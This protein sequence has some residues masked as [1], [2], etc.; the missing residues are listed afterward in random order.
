[1]IFWLASYPKSGNTWLRFF[2]L[3]LLIGKK[4]DLNLNHLKAII[5]YP[6]KSQFKDLLLDNSNLEEVA[7]NWIT[8]QNK[9]NSDKT[10]RFFKTHNM[11]G[12]F[13]NYPFTDADNTLATIHIVRDPRNVITSLKNHYNLN[14]YSEAKDFLFFDKQIL[15]LSKQEK[16]KYSNKNH[17]LPQII[18]SWKTHYLSWKNMKKNYLLVKYEDLIANPINGFMKISKFISQNLKL[19][20]SDEQI[21]NAIKSSSFNNLKEMENT[22]GFTESSTNE[23]GNKNKFFYLGPKNNW[24][25][26]LDESTV[27]N[28]N[29]EFKL[30]MKELDYL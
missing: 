23:D 6:D 2:I 27:N 16:E 4:T 14:N 5:S 28:I 22:Y 25:N 19:K 30:E 24:E 3:S 9:I 15:T 17:P 10:I 13:K 21:L 8:S 1:M 7:K 26:I 29:R 12:S 18:G 11:L 20:F